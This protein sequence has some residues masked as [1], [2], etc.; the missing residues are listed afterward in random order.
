[1][2]VSTPPLLLTGRINLTIQRRSKGG[3]VGGRWV[4]GATEDV[5]IV[6]NVQPVEKSTDTRMLPEALRSQA[7]L[8]VYSK[9]PIR[10]LK[11]GDLG[12][13]ADRFLWEGEWYEVMKTINYKMG[14]LDHYKAVCKRV[15]LT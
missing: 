3:Y 13:D 14:V 8:K 10:E 7:T 2:V 15:E 5:V 6:A 1:M 9:N 11:Q 4:D 12:W